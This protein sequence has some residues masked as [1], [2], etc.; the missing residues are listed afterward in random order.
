MEQNDIAFIKAFTEIHL[1]TFEMVK[2]EMFKNEWSQDCEK[3][4]RETRSGII[5]IA[6]NNLLEPQMTFSPLT[7]T[8]KKEQEQTRIEIEEMIKNI[9]AEWRR[10]N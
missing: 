2:K 7:R 8:F 3:L 4:F 9:F 5:Y 1:K 10:L 6:E